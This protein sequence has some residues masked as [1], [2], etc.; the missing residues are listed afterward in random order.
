MPQPTTRMSSYIA[1]LPKGLES[2]PECQ[3]KGT[4]V[5]SFVLDA[6]PEATLQ[7]AAL[8]EPV[9]TLLRTPPLN[10]VWVPEVQ[11]FACML[12]V[13][14]LLGFADDAAWKRWFQER[15]QQALTNPVLR[16][17]MNFTSAEMLLSLGG[18]F[19]S[20]THR[21]SKLSVV[22]KA[23]HGATFALEYPHNLVDAQV[24][25]LLTV[26]L[27]VPLLLTRAKAPVVA[28]ASSTS[29]CSTYKGTW[30]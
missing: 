5:R 9:A 24:A 25:D 30:Q 11:F 15:N 23:S 7:A 6:V 10:S 27:T 3:A 13:R 26:A 21:G 16:L 22:E 19:W 4:I 20:T 8:P 12:A 17:V 28:L 2:Y 18:T 14:D 1:G 29:T